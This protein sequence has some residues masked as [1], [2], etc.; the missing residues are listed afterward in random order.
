MYLYYEGHAGT[1]VTKFRTPAGSRRGKLVRRALGHMSGR[2]FASASRVALGSARHWL[3]KQ[4]IAQALTVA[5]LLFVEL[6][7]R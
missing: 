4:P 6:K 5:A 1:A 3:H 7:E 2:I